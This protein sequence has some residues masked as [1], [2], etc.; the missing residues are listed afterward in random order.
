MSRSDA[1]CDN[2]FADLHT[3]VLETL[4][5]NPLADD[6]RF[7]SRLPQAESYWIARDRLT[8]HLPDACVGISIH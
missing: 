3:I 2:H 4:H 5:V 6:Y 8:Q 1:K 7:M